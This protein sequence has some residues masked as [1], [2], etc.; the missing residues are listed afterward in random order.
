VWKSRPLV[1]LDSS[2]EE[3]IHRL[4]TL[5]WEFAAARDWSHAEN[6]RSFAVRIMEF[7]KLIGRLHRE[8]STSSID[9]VREITGIIGVF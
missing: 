3:K 8:G 5:F 9:H 6:G 4:L 7:L 1:N 2:V